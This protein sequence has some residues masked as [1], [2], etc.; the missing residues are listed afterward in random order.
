MNLF[1]EAFCGAL[2]NISH[3]ADV[4]DLLQ[5]ILCCTKKVVLYNFALSTDTEAIK[6]K[7]QI[8]RYNKKYVVV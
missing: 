8:S 7:S 1:F 2:L 4:F 6:M 3:N 5:E